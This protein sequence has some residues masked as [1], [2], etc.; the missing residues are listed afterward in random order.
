MPDF[1][2]EAFQISPEESAVFDVA[3]RR[4]PKG[5][6]PRPELA[7][8]DQLPYPWP[9]KY[10][11]V[12]RQPFNPHGFFTNAAALANEYRRRTDPAVAVVA[13]GLYE[14]MREYSTLRAD[15]RFLVYTFPKSYRRITV[16][17]PWTSAYA[18]GAALIALTLLGDSGAIDG[19][20]PEAEQ[21]L[22]GLAALRGRAV[23]EDLWVSFVDN[24]G[25]LWFEEMPLPQEDQPRILNGHIRALTGLY[26]YWVRR[27]SRLALDLLRA[28]TLTVKR[29]AMDYRRPGQVNSYDLLQPPIADYGPD[30]TV[31]QQD[32]LWRMTGDEA[33]AHYRDAFAS[34][35]AQARRSNDAVAKTD[36]ATG[37]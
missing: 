37:A 15:S 17:P 11:T 16:H 18:S 23:G 36:S 13:H 7:L 21:I 3:S 1:A 9:E 33:F 14:R 5:W 34:D 19:E 30:R 29:H 26:I 27:S 24:D 35:I 12:F 10:L 32:F 25:C 22:R 6:L 31:I 28:G 4:A 20:V 8:D 2:T